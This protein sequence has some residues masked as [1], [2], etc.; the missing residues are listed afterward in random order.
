MMGFVK[1]ES[2]AE[3]FHSPSLD[4]VLMMILFWGLGWWMLRK[5]R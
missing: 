1:I 4:G 5:K 3:L 2:D